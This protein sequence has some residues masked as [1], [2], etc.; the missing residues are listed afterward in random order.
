[1]E[2]SKKSSLFR[3]RASGPRKPHAPE[4][5]TCRNL[6]PPLEERKRFFAYLVFR[7]H[8]RRPR[9]PRHPVLPRPADGG[10]TASLIEMHALMKEKGIPIMA[11]VLTRKRG[12]LSGGTGIAIRTWA[13]PR[14]K[15]DTLACPKCDPKS[16]G[17]TSNKESVSRISRYSGLEAGDKVRHASTHLRVYASA[18]SRA[19]SMGAAGRGL[20]LFA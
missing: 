19:G 7:H 3:D 14:N 8:A 5:T 1:M 10:R 2:K 16:G 11:S 15:V 9:R 12:R 6:H 4:P 13:R 18:L 20:G 17:Q